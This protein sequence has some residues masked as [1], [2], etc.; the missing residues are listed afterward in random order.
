VLTAEIQVSNVERNAVIK[1]VL[2]EVPAPT[3]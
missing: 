1:R 2:D 3:V